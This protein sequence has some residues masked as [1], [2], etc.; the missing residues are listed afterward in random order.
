MPRPKK[1]AENRRSAWIR[2]RISA[3][4]LETIQAKADQAELSIHN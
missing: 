2:Y 1:Q 3:Q 4:E